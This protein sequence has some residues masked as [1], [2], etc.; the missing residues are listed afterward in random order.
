MDPFLLEVS[1]KLAVPAQTP[2]QPP[3]DRRSVSRGRQS[4]IPGSATR[5]TLNIKQLSLSDPPSAYV[6]NSGTAWRHSWATGPSNARSTSRRAQSVG[7]GNGRRT[8]GVRQRPRVEDLKLDCWGELLSEDVGV[9]MRR[10]AEAGFGPDV[11]WYLRI[12]DADDLGAGDG[13]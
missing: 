7:N 5:A 11:S 6:V 2:S 12:W 4:G 8:S 9:M 3:T 1:A 13:E 10:R